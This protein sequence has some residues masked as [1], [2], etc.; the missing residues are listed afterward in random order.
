MTLSD[1]WKE[2]GKNDPRK[3]LKERI[4]S[5]LGIAMPTF[6][7][8]VSGKTKGM[9]KLNKEKIAEIIGKPVNELFPE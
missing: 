3:L 9:S 6:R 5:E 4:I 2:L 1:Y 8:Y 7:K